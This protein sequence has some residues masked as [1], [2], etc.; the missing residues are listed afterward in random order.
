MKR[1]IYFAVAAAA[2]LCMTGC[3]GAAETAGSGTEATETAVTEAA[4]TTETAAE[5]TEATEEAEPEVTFAEENEMEYSAERTFTIPGGAVLID[6]N[7]DLTEYEGISI[8]NGES[9]F[10]FEG[11]TVSEPDSDGNVTITV[12]GSAN[13]P[14]DLLYD[15]SVTNS[16]YRYGY[17][18]NACALFDTYTGLM[19]E[20]STH[21]DASVSA[22]VDIVYD[23]VTYTVTVV[24]DSVWTETAGDWESY[25]ETVDSKAYA[26]EVQLTWT[27]TAP[28]DYDGLCFAFWPVHEYEYGGGDENTASLEKTLV[29]SLAE[30]GYTLDDI[31]AYVKVSD[32]LAE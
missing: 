20:T 3:G 4:E 21:D 19:F 15:W 11:A 32:L 2:A 25:A 1:K 16:G 26:E 13:I 17:G 28:Q 7:G 31:R 23:G 5:V 18:C 12:S 10:T 9:T 24:E 14:F 29:E 27:I 22:A 8:V 6:E 30:D